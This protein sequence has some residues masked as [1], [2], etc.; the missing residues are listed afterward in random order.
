M[1]FSTLFTFAITYF[2]LLPNKLASIIRVATPQGASSVALVVVV[3][4]P[5]AAERDDAAND[6]PAFAQKLDNTMTKLSSISDKIDSGQGSVGKLL[7]DPSL[8]NNAD[9]MLVEM[10][11]LVKAI[12]ENP[13]KYLTIHFKIF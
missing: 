7:V 8:Y 1:R 4:D 13:K 10:R 9:Q 12:R 3:D 2:L 11:N 5:V 6:R